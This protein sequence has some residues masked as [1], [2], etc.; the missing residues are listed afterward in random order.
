M[1][2]SA[3][4]VVVTTS[5]AAIAIV[6]TQH[7]FVCGLQLM[8]PVSLFTHSPLLLL[9]LGSSLAE[10]RQVDLS[11]W[12]NS[13]IQETVRSPFSKARTAVLPINSRSALIYYRYIKCHS[14]PSVWK[15]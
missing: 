15:I 13:K 12:K 3:R 2:E 1:T 9:A 7:S 8:I 5:F 4:A 14:R 10:K 6:S 11:F